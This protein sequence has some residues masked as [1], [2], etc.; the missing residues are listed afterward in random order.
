M[1]RGETAVGT[2]YL[3]Y[4]DF[5]N[6]IDK[7]D[8]VKEIELSNSGEIFLN[9]DL[10]KIMEYAYKK[11]ITLTAYNGVNL[12]TVSD[13]VLEGLVKYDFKKITCS[14]DGASQE[15]YSQYRDGGDFNNVIGNIKKINEYKKK[16]NSQFPE[17]KYQFIIFG[18]NEHEIPKAKKLAED[19]GMEIN[20]KFN[21]D[22]NFSPI[23]DMDFVRKETGLGCATSE[24]FWEKNHTPY[25]KSMCVKMWT[26][27][28]INWD[29]RLLG[30]C[31][32]YMGDFGVNVFDVGLE[33]ALKSEK[34]SY[35]KQMLMNKAEKRADIHCSTCYQY[36]KFSGANQFITEEEILPYL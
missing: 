21:W 13:E 7:N 24:E 14:I 36:Q 6:F 33:Q 29:G 8:F 19:L 4:A 32:M 2:G 10:L 11:G 17:L 22:N 5:V 31:V 9:P 28:Q 23:K 15:T 25:Q 27:P 3:K 12:N 20:F 30:C 26:Q 35:A 16:Y 18:H 1:R 34:F